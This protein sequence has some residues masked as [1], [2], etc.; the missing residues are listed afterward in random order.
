[1]ITLMHIE[2]LSTSDL[3]LF[4]DARQ[5]TNWVVKHKVGEVANS[6]FPPYYTNKIK[7]TTDDVDF[8]TQFNYLALTF[9]DRVY[10]YFVDDISYIS[11]EVIEVSI[12]MDT[13][14][15]YYFDIK[16]GDGEICRK[17]IPR[18]DGNGDI[19]RDYIR[20]NL[21]NG[22]K[23]VQDI[24]TEESD[25]SNFKD[26]GMLVFV[27]S[28]DALNNSIPVGGTTITPSYAFKVQDSAF[29]I[30][31]CIGFVPFIKSNPFTPISVK[32]T[33]SD[34]EHS[35]TLNPCSSIWEASKNNTCYHIYYFPYIDPFV[36]DDCAIESIDIANK[37][38]SINYDNYQI[39]NLRDSVSGSLADYIIE[40]GFNPNETSVVNPP[41]VVKNGV[42]TYLIPLKTPVDNEDFDAWQEPCMIDNNY[43]AYEFG[44]PNASI[45]C[46]L[47]DVIQP[48]LINRYIYDFIDGGRSY[49]QQGFKVRYGTSIVNAD[50][51][52]TTPV[53]TEY[54]LIT[55]QWLNYMQLNR[56]TLIGS[57]ASDCIKGLTISQSYTTSHSD[58]AENGIRSQV[59]KDFSKDSEGFTLD[60]N[61]NVLTK[62]E[63][64]RRRYYEPQNYSKNRIANKESKTD[65]SS[66]PNFSETL[67]T[68]TD[69]ANASAAPSA[70]RSLGNLLNEAIY[71]S[72][73]MRFVSYIAEDFQHV[74]LYYHKNGVLV[75]FNYT[76][77]PSQSFSEY[78]LS[79]DHRVRKYF[80]VCKFKTCDCH[81][82]NAPES[83]D[84]I[85]DLN[86]R[87]MD[88]FRTWELGSDLETLTPMGYF[89]KS[90]PD[91]S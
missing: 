45:S 74:G 61:V 44:Q 11:E 15:T 6:Y 71:N 29:P 86:R 27:F 49:Y 24:I 48:S 83:Q 28:P 32:W 34:G 82:N 58:L 4:T 76:L 30:S 39:S 26:F 90:N 80:N 1:M 18:F 87:L 73:R 42:H 50:N 85:L 75:S 16:V 37:I 60:G 40:Q 88:G 57:V 13:L 59:V 20:E 8:D 70:L 2:G 63:A 67:G 7:F 53:S 62:R 81:L 31:L 89:Y 14:V 38:V 22:I 56:Y 19:N 51:S 12:T 79:S 23:K 66:T 68:I 69:M 35:A 10:Y 5:R 36:G 64:T 3:P 65:S 78:L 55:D 77:T 54:P 9:R 33:E 25:F 91:R 43:L 17:F 84:I 21:S 72:N 52:I 46:N 41:Y 47:Y